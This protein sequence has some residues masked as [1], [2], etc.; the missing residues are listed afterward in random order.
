VHDEQE[1]RRQEETTRTVH[2]LRLLLERLA[3]AI[4]SACAHFTKG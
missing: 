3:R 4:E 2:E 1:Q